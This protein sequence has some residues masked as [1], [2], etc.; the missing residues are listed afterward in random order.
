VGR[1]ERRRVREEQLRELEVAVLRREVEQRRAAVVARR[2]RRRARPLVVGVRVVG[3]LLE[4]GLDVRG[5]ARDRELDELGPQDLAPARTSPGE[6][7]RPGHTSTC[8]RSV[9]S[10][11][12]RPI[13]GRVDGSRRVFEAR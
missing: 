9:E 3:E 6:L 1:V 5:L 11:S 10:T 7:G 8:A 13:V 4:L 12:F 2:V